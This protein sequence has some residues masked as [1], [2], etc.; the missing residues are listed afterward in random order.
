MVDSEQNKP[1]YDDRVQGILRSLAQGKTRDEIALEDGNK[2]WKTID[3]YMRRRNFQWDHH[4]QTYIP[5]VSLTNEWQPI[6]AS[7]A[8]QVVAILAKDGADLRSAAERLGFKDHKELA[9]YM[10]TRGYA[11]DSDTNNYVKQVGKIQSIE[12]ATEKEDN[13]LQS[14]EQNIPNINESQISDDIKDFLPLLELLNKNKERL[15]DLIVPGT[16]V[17]IVPR[18][19]VPGIATTKTIHMMNT[20]VQ[21]VLDFSR[22]KNITQREIFEVALIEFFQKYGYEREVERLLKS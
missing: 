5:K 19:I 21:L 10:N 7:K 9:T 15:I 14:E 3:M 13:P 17:G 18:Y 1:I 22:E 2:N 8:G 20:I 16:K 11:W 4:K 6:D 12:K